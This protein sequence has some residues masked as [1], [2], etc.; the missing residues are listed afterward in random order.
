MCVY[1][2]THLEGRECDNIHVSLYSI[3][4]SYQLQGL[5]DIPDSHMYIATTKNISPKMDLKTYSLMS[6]C[7]RLVTDTKD[8][9]RLIKY[10]KISPSSF[11]TP[12]IVLIYALVTSAWTCIMKTNAKCRVYLTQNNRYP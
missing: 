6:K 7:K 9:G 5:V 4:P 8:R 3:G 2:Y 12:A 10:V 11:N 1:I